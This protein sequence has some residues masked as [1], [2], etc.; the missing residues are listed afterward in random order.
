MVTC[1]CFIFIFI[2]FYFELQTRQCYSILRL[3]L[4]D[5]N[6]NASNNHPVS[7]IDIFILFFVSTWMQEW[8]NLAWENF[9]LIWKYDWYFFEYIKILVDKPTHKWDYQMD[10][11]QLHRFCFGFF[12]K[13]IYQKVFLFS[14]I[15]SHRPFQLATKQQKLSISISTMN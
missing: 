15:Y 6:L 3:N 13:L 5:K 9:G 12:S 1:G 8:L 2:F 10:F 11:S 7:F 14:L 4:L